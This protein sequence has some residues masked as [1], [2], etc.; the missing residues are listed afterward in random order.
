MPLKAT[1]RLILVRI[2]VERAK[3]HLRDLE[4]ELLAWRGKYLSIVIQGGKVPSGFSQMSCD[5]TSRVPMLPA[6]AIAAAGDVVHNL[7]SALDHLVYQ[8]AV[9]GTPRTEPN[10]KVGFPIAKDLKT[11]EFV[12]VKKVQ[13]MRPDAIKAIDALQPYKGGCNGDTLWRIHD[14][15]NSN[16]HRTHF[17]VAHD[18][19]L[20]ADWMPGDYLVRTADAPTFPGVE[21]FDQDV[22]ENMQREMEKTLREPQTAVQGDAMASI[23]QPVR[24]VEFVENL[25]ADSLEPLLK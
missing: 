2:K 21:G 1:D 8:L 16:K 14:L 23:A 13:G 25:V 6:N 4:T 24:W 18:Y 22:Q 11:Y 19:L 20:S 15:D 5:P 12:K 7:R 9:V 17:T 3:K 10:R